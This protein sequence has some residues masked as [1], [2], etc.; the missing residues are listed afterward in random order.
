MPQVA[1]TPVFFHLGTVTEHLI[2]NQAHTSGGVVFIVVVDGHL[3]KDYP[4]FRELEI[5]F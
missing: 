1:A 5:R 2:F 3:T 4:R